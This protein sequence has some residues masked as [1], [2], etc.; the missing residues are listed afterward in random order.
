MIK[1]VHIIAS[2]FA[3]NFATSSFAAV[4]GDSSVNA[5]TA[6]ELLKVPSEIRKTTILGKA[7]RYYK[8]FVDIAFSNE[9]AMSLRWRALMA[10]AEVNGVKATDDLKKLVIMRL[11]L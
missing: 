11:G 10:A 1:K 9:N 5:N 3:L 7:D 4:L 8:P 6:I 2:V